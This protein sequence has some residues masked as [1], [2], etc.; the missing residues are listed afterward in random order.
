VGEE[1]DPFV[2]DELVEV[3]GTGGGL[4]LEV[5]CNGSETETASGWISECYTIYD[6]QYTNR[7]PRLLPMPTLLE[8]PFSTYGH[9][10][11]STPRV[12][13]SLFHNPCKREQS[14]HTIL[15]P[16]NKLEFEHDGGGHELDDGGG[17]HFAHGGGNMVWYD[18]T[19]NLRSSSWF[20]RHNG[21]I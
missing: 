4:C 3:D 11:P 21:G 14:K 13:Y 1:D 12:C 16:A 2:S 17:L 6:I 5:G 9:P 19:R 20:S 7:G 10:W 18:M 8:L 15:K